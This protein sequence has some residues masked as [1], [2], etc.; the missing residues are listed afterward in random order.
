MS[1][2]YVIVA[3]PVAGN[4]S[5]DKKYKLLKI[6]SR[7]IG[8]DIYGLDTTSK[9]EFRDCIRM[10][11]NKYDVIIAAGGDGTFSD[12]I[13]SINLSTNTVAYLPMGTGNALRYALR[14]PRSLISS[15][16][17]IKNG[18]IHN[19]DLIECS[20]K[21]EYAF[22]SSIG[23]EAEVVKEYNRIRSLKR[24]NNK[25]VY[26][27]AGLMA[28][29]K[30]IKKDHKLLSARIFMN[31]GSLKVKNA[32]SIVVTKQ[33]YYGYGM[34]VMPR[35]RFDDGL[36]HM[37]IFSGGFINMAIMILLSF[38]IGNFMGAYYTCDNSITVQ[39]QYEH[40]L[41]INGDFLGREKFFS[42]KIIKN[43]LRIIY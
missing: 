28:F 16:K 33:P 21:K 7:I 41:Q 18:K 29:R 35:A 22:V 6:A 10:L 12:L 19:L 23:F 36:L 3:N 42:F 11:S 30:Y 4:F 27:I 39:L 20:R 24:V 15:A 17:K 34:K 26:V 13:N 5:L 25:L 43:I 8:A 38:S 37:G 9:E 1:S 31:G 40:G 32:I 2:S 14:Y